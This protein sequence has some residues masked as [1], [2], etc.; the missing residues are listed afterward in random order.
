VSEKASVFLLALA[1]RVASQRGIDMGIRGAI[2]AV[3][4]STFSI[5]A[6]AKNV[7]PPFGSDGLTQNLFKNA[8]FDNDASS[9]TLSQ[10]SLW[11]A[12][13]H[14]ADN[15][16]SGSVLVQQFIS[17]PIV[18][19]G[20]ISQCVPVDAGRSYVIA[21]WVRHPSIVA[22]ECA[23]PAWEFQAV[24]WS[25]DACGFN[26]DKLGSTESPDQT[27]T[28]DWSL[29]SYGV[30]A[31]EFSRSANV[32]L[33]TSCASLN[34]NSAYFFDD[35]SMGIDVIFQDDFEGE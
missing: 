18:D 5:T 20:V 1:E 4:V 28:T 33:L 7:V 25:D 21:T 32:S 23:F 11:T 6:S 24:W 15:P 14:T 19:H 17:N 30:T 16:D 12:L 22:Q 31:P 29:Q 8:S 2:V 35:V 10:Q 26:G 27:A 3:I 34:G 9:W 13:N